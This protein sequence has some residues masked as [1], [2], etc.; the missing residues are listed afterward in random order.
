MFLQLFFILLLPYNAEQFS[1]IYENW[2]NM[3]MCGIYKDIIIHRNLVWGTFLLG[4][5]LIL[6]RYLFVGFIIFL[7]GLLKYYLQLN[8]WCGVISKDFLIENK[9]ND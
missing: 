4:G 3:G 7:L 1:I 5:F 9:I 8:K 6:Y 2:G